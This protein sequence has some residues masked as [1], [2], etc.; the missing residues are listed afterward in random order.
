MSAAAG[1]SDGAFSTIPVASTR[2]VRDQTTWLNYAACFYLLVIMGS[3][4][5]AMPFIRDQ[6]DINLTIAGLHFSAVALGALTAAI[7][8]THIVRALGRAGAFWASLA[9]VTIGGLMFT[10][11]PMAVVSILGTAL[12]GASASLMTIVVQANLSERHPA[13]RAV[14]LVEINVACSLGTI[15]AAFSVGLSERSGAGWQFAFVVPM[16]LMMLA[17]FAMRSA[18]FAPGKLP[19]VTHSQHGSLP[20]LFWVLCAIAALSSAGEW[21]LMYWGSD[22]LNDAGDVSKGAAAAMM[23]LFFIGMTIGRFVGSRL[24][25]T[26]HPQ[27]LL[28]AGLAIAIVGFP[29]FWLPQNTPLR[30]FGLLI[31][32]LGIS[33][34]YP[35]IASLSSTMLPRMIDIAFSRLQ[36]TGN[37]MIFIAPFVLGVFGDEFGIKTAMF[38]V[39]PMVL[40]ALLLTVWFNRQPIDAPPN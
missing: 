12:I 37:I 27:R 3:I 18:P 25:R 20:R 26:L 17:A 10:F 34:V 16:V 30:L 39:F 31:L 11:A 8:L 1:E 19:G 36:I 35:T 24:I 21:S 33:N 29:I 13:H 14:A 15:V 4:G 32:G 22:F 6:R 23:S 2:F 38:L 7:F 9:G 5:P 28:T 40:S